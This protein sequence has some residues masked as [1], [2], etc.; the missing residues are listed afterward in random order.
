MGLP[1]Q[2]LSTPDW[3]LRIAVSVSDLFIS[4]TVSRRAAVGT[5]MNAFCDRLDLMVTTCFIAP[6]YNADT[7][8]FRMEGEAM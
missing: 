3:R 2:A 6:E 8:Q 1:V 5:F 7:W 4:N